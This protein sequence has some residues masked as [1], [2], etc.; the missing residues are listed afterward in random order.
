MVKINGLLVKSGLIRDDKNGHKIELEI[1][2]IPLKNIGKFV[3]NIKYPLGI[4]NIELD[5][6]TFVKGFVCEKIFEEKCENI[7]EYK[8]FRNYLN[9]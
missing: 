8:S 1:F 6:G 5:D 7:S 4:G 3:E 2:N 9:K